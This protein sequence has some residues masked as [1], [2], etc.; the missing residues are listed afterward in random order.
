MIVD[1][2]FP[3]VRPVRGGDHPLPAAVCLLAGDRIEVKRPGRL[4]DKP[5]KQTEAGLL[6]PHVTVKHMGPFLLVGPEIPF[7]GPALS[8][9]DGCFRIGRRGRPSGRLDNQTG[10]VKMETDLLLLAG[11]TLLFLQLV[12]HDEKEALSL[13]GAEGLRLDKIGL[14]SGRIGLLVR[15][16]DL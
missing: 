9:L 3:E 10:A 13:V 2:K 16:S 7:K 4:D 12:P 8:T 5:S 14:E 11:E 6:P 15:P 1:H